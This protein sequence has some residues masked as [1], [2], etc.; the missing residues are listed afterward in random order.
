MCLPM[1]LFVCLFVC[2]FICPFVCCDICT[3]FRAFRSLQ[4]C[5]IPAGHTQLWL[6]LGSWPP[7]SLHETTANWQR[8]ISPSPRVKTSER[9]QNCKYLSKEEISNNL[10]NI[11]ISEIRPA[12]S[13]TKKSYSWKDDRLNPWRTGKARA[14]ME[15]HEQQHG[16]I[17][18]CRGRGAR[19]EVGELNASGRKLGGVRGMLPG[20]IREI[21]VP[22]WLEMH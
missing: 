14:D 1:C 10:S 22:K 16:D 7:S 21:W 20:E 12:S 15:N 19:S 5:Q 11:C 13:S 17:T 6:L 18:V 8:C 9:N 4:V 3:R 2:L